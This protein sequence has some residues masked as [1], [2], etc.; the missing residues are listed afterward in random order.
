MARKRKIDNA[1]LKR[2]H[3][4]H[5]REKRKANTRAIRQYFLIICEGEKTEPNYFQGFRRDLPRGLIELEI[6]GVGD[7][8]LNLVEMAVGKRDEAIEQVKHGG[9]EH[10]YD[11][12]WVV[13]DKDDFSA[14]RFNSAVFRAKGCDIR[15]AYSNEAFE[16]W[17]LLH[18]ENHHTAI[19]RSRYQSLLGNYLGEK[20]QKKSDSMYELLK[21]RGDQMQAIRWAK[22]LYEHYDHKNPAQENPSTTVF[23]LVEELNKFIIL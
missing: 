12:V 20:Y 18:F 3:Q 22:D 14:D 15:C 5:E 19:Q 2:M 16:L 21:K 17:Y 11:Q 8:T 6:V 7:N 1:V 13:F 23:E 10:A 9:K 4:K